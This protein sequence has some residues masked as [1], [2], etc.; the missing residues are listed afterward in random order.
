MSKVKR[1]EH[2]QP[3]QLNSYQR[4]YRNIKLKELVQNFSKKEKVKRYL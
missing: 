2:K 1:L 3:I 4:K